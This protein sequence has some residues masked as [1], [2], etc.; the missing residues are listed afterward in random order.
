MV[1]LQAQRAARE[2]RLSPRAARR[3][4]ALHVFVDHD[5]VVEQALKAS[6]GDL[7]PRRVEPRGAK[8]DVIRLPLAGGARGVGKGWMA[9]VGSP[10]LGDPAGVD[11]P[12]GAVLQLA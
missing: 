12:A 5:A 11:A 6:V 2:V 7:L 3:A 8:G 10:G 1:A 9:V 4:G